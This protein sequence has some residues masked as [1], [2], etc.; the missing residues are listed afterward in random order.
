MDGHK[1]RVTKL[2]CNLVFV[3]LCV[4]VRVWRAPCAS[5][6]ARNSAVARTTAPAR[7]T[8]WRTSRSSEKPRRPHHQDCRGEP[9]QKALERRRLTSRALDGEAPPSLLRGRVAASC[10]QAANEE[11]TVPVVGT[12]PRIDA[13]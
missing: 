13:G 10:R 3:W 7:A 4:G 2:N 8:L 5:R 9:E 1:E 11:A 6:R 12:A